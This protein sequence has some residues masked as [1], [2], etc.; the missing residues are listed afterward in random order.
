MTWHI[1]TLLLPCEFIHG[2]INHCSEW[3][4]MKTAHLQ[5]ALKEPHE[6]NVYWY[7]W[8]VLRNMVEKLQFQLNCIHISFIYNVWNLRLKNAEIFT[9]HAKKNDLIPNFFPLLVVVVV[10][11][12]CFY[13]PSI[14][15]YHHHIRVHDCQTQNSTFLFK[16]KKKKN[17]YQQ[18]ESENFAEEIERYFTEW[19]INKTVWNL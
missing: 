8:R 18:N 15:P 11:V 17:P 19:I 1:H 7:I 3:N 13:W 5:F 12:F 9:D 2:F 14:H 10:A 16:I 6:I 4:E